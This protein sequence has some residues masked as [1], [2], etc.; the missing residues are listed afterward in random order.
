MSTYE[1][2]IFI[3]VIKIHFYR[4]VTK[5]YS[6]HSHLIQQL[7]W[8]I[9]NAYKNKAHKSITE[10]MDKKEISWKSEQAWKNINKRTYF[11]WN[12]QCLAVFLGIFMMTSIFIKKHISLLLC[13]EM[14][15]PKIVTW[16][17]RGSVTLIVSVQ[18]R[19][20]K[21]TIITWRKSEW[22]NYDS[23][24]LLNQKIPPKKNVRISNEK[25]IKITKYKTVDRMPSFL[26]REILFSI[27]VIL[28]RIKVVQYIRLTK[29]K[30]SKKKPPVLKCYKII[31]F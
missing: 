26:S 8:Q 12:Q 31:Y 23:N 18:K 4:L 3:S 15:L 9:T 13:C 19:N 21:E 1:N 6:H 20:W 29:V 7:L 10:I 28:K 27:Q 24:G 17:E 5:F 25:M 2:Y 22:K 30:R 14:Y 11:G 16:V